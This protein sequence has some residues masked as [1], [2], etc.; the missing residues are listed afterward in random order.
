[1]VEEKKKKKK[2]LEFKCNPYPGDP[3]LNLSK[4]SEQ[5]MRN[6]DV[7]VTFR[8]IEEKYV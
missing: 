6:S 1:M 7:F 3:K 4:L 8:V 2:F 5:G